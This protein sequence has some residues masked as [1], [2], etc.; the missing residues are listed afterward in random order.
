MS[1]INPIAK[2]TLVISVVDYAGYPIPGAAVSFE[3]IGDNTLPLS[4]GLTGSGGNYVIITTGYPIGA[5]YTVTVN[6]N[7]YATGTT[8]TPVASFGTYQTTVTLFPAELAGYS[9]D[10]LPTH[11]AI[12]N[13]PPAVIHAPDSDTYR[14]ALATISNTVNADK[15]TLEGVVDSLGVASIALDDAL[16]V[17]LVPFLITDDIDVDPTMSRK[18]TVTAS[19]EDG[20]LVRAIGARNTVAVNVAGVDPLDYINSAGVLANWITPWPNS[21]IP[22]TIGTY[23]DV[24]ILLTAGDYKLVTLQYGSVEVA[25]RADWPITSDGI[26]LLRVRIPQPRPGDNRAELKIKTTANV[27]VSETLNVYYRAE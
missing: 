25:Q 16:S 8:T 17:P 4:G 1:T 5:M 15:P 26:K 9:V 24:S 14:F 11:V 27:A 13:P 21:T 7:G 22:H 10:A 6:A 23:N 18:Y 12:G 20:A 19:V 2:P 3:P